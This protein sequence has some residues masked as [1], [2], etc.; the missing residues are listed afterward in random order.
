MLLIVPGMLL[1]LAA[2]SSKLEE[3]QETN[4][5]DGTAQ[6]V[7]V[8]SETMGRVNSV[9]PHLVPYVVS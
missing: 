9:H 2:T 4:T 6:N 3:A 5:G 1:R 8:G 7:N